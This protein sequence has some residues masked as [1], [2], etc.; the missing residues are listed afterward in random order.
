MEP[1]EWSPQEK[2]WLAKD[3]E[4]EEQ[5]RDLRE[6][7]SKKM[8]R[9]ALAGDDDQSFW[10]TLEPDVRAFQDSILSKKYAM[11]NASATFEMKVD[12]EALKKA[13][14]SLSGLSAEKPR[15]LITEVVMTTEPE[16]VDVTS[17]NDPFHTYTHSSYTMT[18]KDQDNEPL[19]P[20]LVRRLSEMVS[21]GFL[22]EERIKDILNEWNSGKEE[23]GPKPLAELPWGHQSTCPYR[24]S[25]HFPC[26][27]QPPSLFGESKLWYCDCCEEARSPIQHGLCEMCEAHQ[28]SDGGQADLEHTLAREDA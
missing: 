19:A 23:K 9:V 22:S 11:M 21:G 14:G 20:D 5:A 16:M 24:G 8:D 6:R 27:C 4:L 12:G 15:K 13:F 18:W 26:T 17:M 28:Y 1:R 7:W 3:P 10:A 2:Y 25:H